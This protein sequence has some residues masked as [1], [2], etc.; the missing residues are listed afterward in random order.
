[1]ERIIVWI[2]DR[3]NRGKIGAGL[4]GLAMVVIAYA[5]L[6]IRVFRPAQSSVNPNDPRQAAFDLWWSGTAEDR[7]KL[8]TSRDK[9]CPGAPFQLPAEGYIGLYY[10]DPRPPYSADHRHQGIDIFSPTPPNQTP[11]YAAYDGYLT[12]EAGWV[13]AVIMRVPSDPLHPGRQIWLYYTHMADA[14][15][16]VDFISPQFP[17]DTHEVFVKQGTLLGHTGN[18]S[19]DPLKPVGTHLHFS[20]VRDNGQGGYSNELIFDNTIDS[21]RYLGLPVNYNC[22]PVVPACDPNPLCGSAYLGAGGG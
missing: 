15:G 16:T 19:G 2:T 12:R 9:V 10:G 5:F 4:L 8:I 7:A 13:S 11:V 18:W 22:A 14:S 1:V 17:R 6:R 20:I 21:S 3:R